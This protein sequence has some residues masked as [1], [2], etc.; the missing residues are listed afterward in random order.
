M[1]HYH[2]GPR[3]EAVGFVTGHDVP[4]QAVPPKPSGPQDR[5]RPGTRYMHHERFRPI[6]NTS[7]L[8]VPRPTPRSV[9]MYHTQKKPSPILAVSKSNREV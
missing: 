4:V 9:S 5:S 8:L 6:W 3:A 7:Y 2:D 1:G